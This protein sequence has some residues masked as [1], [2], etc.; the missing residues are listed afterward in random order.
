[1]NRREFIKTT[2]I[3]GAGALLDVKKGRSEPA[4]KRGNSPEIK[5]ILLLFVDQHRQD[6]C[7]C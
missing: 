2:E 4:N 7:G 1:M 3:A 6:C 5:N